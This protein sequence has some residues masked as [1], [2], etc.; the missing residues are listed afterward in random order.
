MA[1]LQQ[2][3]FSVAALVLATIVAENVALKL[4]G[5][6][7]AYR[8]PSKILNKSQKIAILLTSG[9]GGVCKGS[10]RLQHRQGGSE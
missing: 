6:E 3:K 7:W 1:V 2:M 5:P 9:M 4:G 8:I 10:V